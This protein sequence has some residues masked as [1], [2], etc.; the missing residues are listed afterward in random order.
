MD[1]ITRT[2]ALTLQADLLNRVFQDGK[3]SNGEGIGEYSKGYARLRQS[4]GRQVQKVDLHF[5]GKLLNDFVVLGKNANYFLGFRSEYGKNVSEE[6]ERRFKK[7]IFN[8]TKAERDIIMRI[9]EGG[10]KL[11]L[12]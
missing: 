6:N 9:F 10:I 12:R 2:A 11:V 5:T 8:S 3:A 7:V 4:K 1:K